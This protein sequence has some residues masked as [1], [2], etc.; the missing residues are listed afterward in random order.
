MPAA[1]FSKSGIVAAFAF[2]IGLVVGT[3]AEEPLRVLV[4]GEEVRGKLPWHLEEDEVVGPVAPLA[5]ALRADK[6]RWDPDTHS[7]WIHYDTSPWM[8][9]ERSTTA[10][11]VGPY[12][13]AALG[14]VLTLRHY[15]SLAQWESLNQPPGSAEPVLARFE[16]IDALSLAMY[17]HP[18]DGTPTK[19]MGEDGFRLRAILYWVTLDQRGG[20]PR[21]AA[22]II[23][24]LPLAPGAVEKSAELQKIEEQLRAQVERM[25]REQEGL[26]K[27][28]RYSAVA[29]DIFR[30]LQYDSE[31]GLSRTQPITQRGAA[32]PRELSLETVDY[33]LKPDGVLAPREVEGN[34]GPVKEVLQGTSG[35]EVDQT[36]TRQVSAETIPIS[37]WCNNA[38]PLYDI[39]VRKFP[40][41][42]ALAPPDPS[43]P[44]PSSPGC[45]W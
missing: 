40:A 35:W 14:P 18:T 2:A 20:R 27:A 8:K 6:V 11:S 31:G 4:N 3:A 43:L 33:V 22:R 17:P 15:L 42:P 25:V 13:F 37:D 45:W 44:P 5:E 16:I 30:A 21:G 39:S 32:W 7:L 36:Q 26:G 1:R 10:G 24:P 34:Y 29:V 9:V 19:R 28:T 38:V 23:S 12:S 41:P